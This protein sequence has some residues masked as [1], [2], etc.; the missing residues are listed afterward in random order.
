MWHLKSAGEHARALRRGEVSSEELVEHYIRRIEALD[1]PEEGVNAVVVRTFAEARKRAR[2]ADRALARGESWGPLHG[3]PVTVKENIWLAGTPTTAAI[4]EF[5]DFVAQST[6]PA[7]QRYLDAG[8]VVLGKTNVPAYT[9]DL[10]S[11]N[12]RYG[13]T[14]NPWDLARIVGGSS[15]GSAA[16]MAAGFAAL[17][18][19]GDQAGSLRNPAHFCG[20][21]S[22]KPSQGVVPSH[23]RFPS[24][25]HPLYLL[26]GELPPALREREV[27]PSWQHGVGTAGPMGRSCADLELAMRVLAGPEPLMAA[28]GWSFTLP[29]ARVT[30]VSSLR[31]ACWLDDPFSP[32]EAECVALLTKAARALEANGARVSFTAR[33]A[34]GDP[35]KATAF[36][37]ES[38]KAFMQLFIGGLFPEQAAK[39]TLAEHA[40]L[41]TARH[42]AKQVWAEFFAEGW[43]VLLCPVIPITAIPHDHSE[44]MPKRTFLVNGRAVNYLVH[45]LRWAGL[46]NFA[47][48]PATVVPVGRDAS[49]LPCGVQ[50]M[51]PVFQDLQTIEVGKMMERL[52][53]AYV[54]PPGYEK[55]VQQT[56]GGAGASKL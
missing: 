18:L 51:G 39:T 35:Q 48:L 33:P 52:G 30:E 25:N 1:T 56:G 31:V 7:V 21:C 41:L 43:D 14:R 29:P 54:P 19:G 15:G 27:D 3:V 47:D 16:S 11:Y 55:E 8:A 53:C 45:A 5:L 37:E 42:R 23:G 2:E 12:P 50:I 24:P 10:Q 34:G 4:P 22:H 9:A 26:P 40:K 20:V 6:A 32:V 17:E 46:A 49:G 13:T 38:E 44:P 28:N 36:L